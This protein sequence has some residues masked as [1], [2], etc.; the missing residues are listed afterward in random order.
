[1]QSEVG[2]VIQEES[3]EE[4]GEANDSFSVADGGHN[5]SYDITDGGHNDSYDITDG[6]HDDSYEMTDGGHDDSDLVHPTHPLDDS[7]L[8][9]PTQP[10]WFTPPTPKW[11]ECRFRHACEIV[12]CS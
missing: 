11:Q 7:D 6:G 12:W 5:D 2:Q 3:E 8:V 1:M 4:T 9:H 10:S